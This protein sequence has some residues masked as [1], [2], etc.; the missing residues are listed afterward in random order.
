MDFSPK[1]WSWHCSICLKDKCNMGKK[2]SREKKRKKKR[3]STEGRRVTFASEKKNNSYFQIFSIDYSYNEVWFYFIFLWHNFTQTRHFDQLTHK[4]LECLWHRTVNNARI[5]E[6]YM[7]EG[8]KKLL[9]IEFK[10][11]PM[12]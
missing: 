10:V 2:R 3:L 1:P 7:K 11:D 4:Q 5:W 6:M 12:Q 9:N 8:K